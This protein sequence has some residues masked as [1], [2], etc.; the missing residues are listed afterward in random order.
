MNMANSDLSPLWPALGGPV[1]DYITEPPPDNFLRKKKRSVVI[2]GCTGS[3]G[4]N[5]LDVVRK[6]D[7]FLEVLA[8]GAGGNITLLAEQYREFTPHFLAVRDDDCAKRLKEIL[9]HSPEILAGGPGY[10]HL[11]SLAEAD[12]ILCAQAGSAGLPA[13]L[14]AALAGKI[15]VLANKESLVLAGTLLKRICKRTNATILP[16]DSEHYA[17][18]QCMAGRGQTI[19][20]LVLTA[21]GGPFRGKT[22]KEL[23][24]IGAENALRHPTWQMGRKITIDSATLMNKGLEMIEAA[25]LFGIKSSEIEILVHPQSIVHSLV[26]FQDNSLLAQL[27]VPDMRLPIGGC[28]T[29]P[30]CD[31]P[32]AAPLDLTA[33]PLTFEKPD[34]QIFPCLELARKALEFQPDQA[35]QTFGLNPAL[36]VMNMANEAAVDLYLTGRCGFYD[37]PGFIRRAMAE[38][39]PPL[40][41]PSV[42]LSQL[43]DEALKVINDIMVKIDSLIKTEF[44]GKRNGDISRP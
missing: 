41:R 2:L 37:I 34:S 39:F 9:P 1:I 5:A 35:W 18:F 28:L 14:A 8:L 29:W 11:A 23:L 12:I 38:P 32:F 25:Q 44:G 17:L 15:I 10:T 24:H 30:R 3:I 33:A 16:L 21:S 31:T 36:L 27:A 4:R 26:E 20:K 7:G 13:T 40:P 19:K 22:R 6:S 43:A 42:T